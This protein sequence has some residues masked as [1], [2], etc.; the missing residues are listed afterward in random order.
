MNLAAIPV[1][2]SHVHYWNP[3][4]L[5]Y[6]WLAGIPALNRAWEPEHYAEATA[7]LGVT[8]IVF[9]ECGR[10]ATQNVEE[11]AWVADLARR[12]PRI[13]GVVAHA[14]V[15]R[16]GAV[17]EELAVLAR[18][19]LVRGVR[20][21]LQDESEPGFCLRP[22]FIEGVRALSEFGFSFDLC[23]YHHQLRAVTE[24]VRRCPGVTFVLDHVAKPAIR[25]GRLDPWR[26]E[27]R[28]LARLPEVWCKL[29]G[30]ATEADPARWSE[31]DLRPWGEHVIEC[32]G[33]DRLMFGGDWPVATL[34]TSWARW[35]GCVRSF[36]AGASDRDQVS[37]FSG[38]AERCYRLGGR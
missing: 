15:E 30:M 25:E 7:G 28:E 26:A 16:G 37:L 10:L 19:P 1:I 18:Q 14:S 6:P 21:L 33:F 8:G 36:V 12:E 22:D 34:A 5:S 13:R 2:D 31:S 29:S 4:R 24:L 27:L 23:I 38:N 17:R 32:F 9:V 11:A 35:L 20:R 3:A